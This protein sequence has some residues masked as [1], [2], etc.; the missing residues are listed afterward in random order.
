MYVETNGSQALMKQVYR[1]ALDKQG[2]QRKLRLN[3]VHQIEDKHK[4]IATLKPD[5]T[6]GYLLFAE[7]LDPRLIDQFNYF[8]LPMMIDL[9]QSMGPCVSSKPK[10]ERFVLTCLGILGTKTQNLQA[11]WINQD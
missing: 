6:N 5:I 1:D 10:L 3:R 11:F 2:K 7:D 4:R 8:Q 9:M